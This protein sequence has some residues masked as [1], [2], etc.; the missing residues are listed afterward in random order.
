[1]HLSNSSSSTYSDV[2]VLVLGAAGFIGRW[3]ARYLTLQKASLALAVL[4]RD[5]AM[6]VFSQYGIKGEIYELDLCN[7]DYLIKVLNRVRPAVVFN[8]AGY[9]V[10]RNERDEKMSYLINRDLVN[11][12]TEILIDLPNLGWEGQRLVHVG[13]AL[14]YGPIEG[15]LKEESTP[16]PTTLYGKSKLAGTLTLT[17]SCRKSHLKGLTARLFTVYGPGEHAG[18]LLPSLLDASRTEAT[19]PLTAG[20]QQRDFTYVEDIAEGLLRLGR[21][22][23][24]SVHVVNLATGVLQSVRQFVETAAGILNLAPSQLAYSE[25]PTRAEEMVH[26]PVNIHLLRTM[27]D[28]VPT[29]SIIQGISK[30]VR[31][32]Q[33]LSGSQK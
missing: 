30:T 22:N 6:Q 13:S 31:F 7:F 3:V 1:M 10:Q 32:T 23:S 9:G 33:Q 16:N 21:V 20:W 25:L 11:V 28:W 19:L 29:H 4:E 18:R 26:D 2:N 24:N 27:L 12:L 8:L 17:D 5:S 14:E 15:D